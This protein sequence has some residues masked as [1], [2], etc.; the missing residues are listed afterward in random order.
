MSL[1]LIYVLAK[2]EKEAENMQNISVQD[3][4]YESIYG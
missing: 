3:G 2:R 4:I 1:V